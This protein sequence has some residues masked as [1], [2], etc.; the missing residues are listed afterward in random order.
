MPESWRDLVGKDEAPLPVEE[1]DLRRV[2]VGTD[3]GN[4]RTRNWWILRG[5]ADR[6]IKFSGINFSG[7][8]VAVRD[9][10]RTRS[11]M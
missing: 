7:A 6:G 5:L 1:A 9:R 8:G 11:T 10:K 2:C 4:T 3:L